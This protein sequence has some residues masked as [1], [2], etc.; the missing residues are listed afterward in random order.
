MHRNVEVIAGDATVREAAEQM[1]NLDVGSLPVCVNDRIVGLITDRDLVV[2]SLARGDDPNKMRV[3]D[4]MTSK[5]EWCFEDEPIDEASRKM[6]AC[7][8]QRLIVL[9]RD[10]RLVGIV[11]LADLVRGRGDAP[12]VTHIIEEIKSPTKSSAV[13]TSAQHVGH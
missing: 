7:Q 2:R 5:V 8:I 13:G 9:N 1:S 4:V 3:S 6:S 10:K 11:S 12:A